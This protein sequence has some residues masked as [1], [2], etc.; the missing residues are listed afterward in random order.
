MHSDR[1]EGGGVTLGNPQ[2]QGPECSMCHG[3]ALCVPTLQSRLTDRPGALREEAICQGSS[4]AAEAGAFFGGR[5][6]LRAAP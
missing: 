6:R 4:S 1:L 3:P 2:K 5:L